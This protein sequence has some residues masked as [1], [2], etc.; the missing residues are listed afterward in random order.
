MLKV[1]GYLD[2]A[3]ANEVQIAV[4]QIL[5]ES[6]PSI[7]LDLSE[8]RYLSS[9]GVGLIVSTSRTAI[10]LKGKAVCLEPSKYVMGIFTAMNLE[11]AFIICRDR[12]DLAGIL[13]S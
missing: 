6:S 11:D 8:L 4:N 10:D 1:I 9:A 5:G 7:I 13:K 2:T 3:N 12:K